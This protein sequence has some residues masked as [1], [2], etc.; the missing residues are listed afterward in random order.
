MFVISF[1]LFTSFI[2][3]LSLFILNPFRN[4]FLLPSSFSFLFLYNLRLVLFLKIVFPLH[5]VFFCFSFLIQIGHLIFMKNFF[6]T[7]FL[8]I[9]L[10]SVLFSSDFLLRIIISYLFV[11]L[12]YFFFIF[13]LPFLILLFSV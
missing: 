10:F 1:F 13:F 12:P 9:P 3:F 8:F 4:N 6:L 11:M 2:H 7:D 5:L